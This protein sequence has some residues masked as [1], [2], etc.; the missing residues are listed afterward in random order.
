VIRP[1]TSAPS[2]SACSSGR[3]GGEALG[4]VA[5]QAGLAETVLQCLD[6]H[7]HEVADLRFHFTA[8]V[9][10]LFDGDEALGLQ[11]RIHHDVVLIDANDFG[12]DDFTCAHLL[13]GEAFLEE[14]GEAVHSGHGGLGGSRHGW[15]GFRWADE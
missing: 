15:V 5:G 7:R 8:I 4:L 6:G 2:S 11:A 12:G 13:T 14:G 1:C 3:P 10:E 9:A